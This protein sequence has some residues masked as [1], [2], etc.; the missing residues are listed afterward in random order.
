M[1]LQNFPLLGLALSLLAVPVRGASQ[2]TSNV[3]RPGD[4]LVL[5]VW[6]DTTLS[7]SYRVEADGHAYLPMLGPVSA[8]ERGVEDLREELIQRY[9]EIMRTPVVVVVP[10]FRV[11]ILG[12]VRSPGLY[13]VEAPT[14]LIDLV[15]M[16]GGFTDNAKPEQLRLL[17][18]TEAFGV[19]AERALETGAS[20]AAVPL[21]SG[22]RIV[23]PTGSIQYLQI[24]QVLVS[25]AT[26]VT[27]I[28][29]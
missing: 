26:L 2:E 9:S 1:R 12:G 16:A 7:G 25:L 18:G 24:L 5:R 15:S 6:P 10:R 3:L 29:R 27:I 19:D 14:T 11:S 28:A 23:I 4:D 8:I 20:T 13:F 21:E 17:R 22:D